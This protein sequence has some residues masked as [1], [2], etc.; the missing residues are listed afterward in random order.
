MIEEIGL[1]RVRGRQTDCDQYVERLGTVGRN[2]Q[3]VEHLSSRLGQIVRLDEDSKTDECRPGNQLEI[4]RP[5][6]LRCHNR[7]PD[8]LLALLERRTTGRKIDRSVFSWGVAC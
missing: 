5:C 8:E 6:V 1:Q 4:L 7:L 2:A 3:E